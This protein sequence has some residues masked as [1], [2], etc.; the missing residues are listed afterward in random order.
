MIYSNSVNFPKIATVLALLCL[1]PAHSEEQVAIELTEII[2]SAELAS[3][4]AELAS[5]FNK[6]TPLDKAKAHNWKLTN[7]EWSRYK[8]LMETTGR[9]IWSPKID[10]ITLLGVEARSDAQMSHYARLF[11]QVETERTKKEIA[12]AFAQ[13]KDL[14]KISPKSNAFISYLEQRKARRISYHNQASLS[15]GSPVSKVEWETTTYVAYVDLREECDSSC[16]STMNKLL[17]KNRIDFYFVGVESDSS[18]Y[19]FAKDNAISS[20]K[21]NTGNI[22]LNYG[23]EDEIPFIPNTIRVQELSGNNNAVDVSW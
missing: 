20:M 19:S 11:N 14:K 18:I 10:P 16:K 7:K 4:S 21:V 9:D 6:L 22:T 3:T 17:D 1:A 15:Q 5:F 12:F 13:S 8:M 23:N 2:T